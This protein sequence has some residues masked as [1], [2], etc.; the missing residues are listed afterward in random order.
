MNEISAMLV[1]MS[2]LEVLFVGMAIGY[3]GQL[4]YQVNKWRFEYKPTKAEC[5]HEH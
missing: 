2:N 1:G 4:V 5:K 3:V